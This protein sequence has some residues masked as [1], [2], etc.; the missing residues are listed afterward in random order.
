MKIWT[1]FYI[2]LSI[3]EIFRNMLPYVIYAKKWVVIQ[4]KK[5]VQKYI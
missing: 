1:L 4:Q 2:W 3:Y 5:D